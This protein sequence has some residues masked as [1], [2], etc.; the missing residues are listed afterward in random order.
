MEAKSLGDFIIV[1]EKFAAAENKS[2]R[3]IEAVKGAVSKF[4]SYL[5]GCSNPR[6]IRPDNLR[7]YIR[8]LQNHPRWSEH[9]TI[10]QTHGILSPG[11]IASY[12]RS[13]RSFWSWMENEKFIDHNPFTQVK[14]PKV[15]VKIVDPLTPKEVS[16]LLKV[17][18]RKSHQG[19]RENCIILTLYGTGLRISELLN[20]GLPNVDFN[21]A[22][23]K[24]MG[25]GAKERTVYM[26]PSVYKALFKYHSQWRP[27]VA[28]D[29]FFVHENGRKLTRFY[30]EHRVQAYVIKAAITKQCTPHIFRYSFAIQFLRNGGDPFTLQKIL[31]HSTLD[32]TRRYVQIASSD[33]EREM[34]SY[35]PAEQLDV[36]F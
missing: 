7:E 1:Y 30:V 36:R 13:I 8:H 20:L 33:V 19:Y 22:Q 26:G 5:G 12:V 2:P 27:K 25:K 4:D 15:P 18:P 28:T 14:P 10:K 16:Q 11:A 21:S 34:K 24:V 9:P 3:T 31:G 6:E 35:S 23:I 17:I 29:H 32:M